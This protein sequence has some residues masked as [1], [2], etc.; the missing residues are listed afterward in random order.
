MKEHKL[1]ID[2]RLDLSVGEDTIEEMLALLDST[3][4][5]WAEICW[6]TDAFDTALNRLR[7]QKEDFMISCH[8]VEVEILESG[9]KLIVY[10]RDADEDHDLTL[11]MLLNGFN[12]HI[13]KLVRDGFRRTN[14]ADVNDLNY[15]D[16]SKI[17]QYAIFGKIIYEQ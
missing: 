11:E 2:V 14:S 6:D 12:R 5:S 9:G 13:P 4:N 7:S 10:D 17:I 8:A 3:V 15:L 1:E 16:A